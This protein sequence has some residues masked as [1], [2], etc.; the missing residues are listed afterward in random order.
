MYLFVLGN[1]ENKIESRRMEWRDERE[2]IED[3]RRMVKIGPSSY[4]EIM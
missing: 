2:G 3:D 1:F 4:Q